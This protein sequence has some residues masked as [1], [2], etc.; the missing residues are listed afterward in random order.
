VFDEQINVLTVTANESYED[1]AGRCKPRLKDECGVTFDKGRIK[2]KRKRKRIKLKKQLELDKNFKELWEKIKHKTRYRVDYATDE[3]IRRAGRVVSELKITSARLVS[4]KARLEMDSG[5][6]EGVLLKETI[7]EVQDEVLMIPDVL[8]AIQGKTHLTRDTLLR[9]LQAAGRVG[10]IYTNPQLF[11]D[12][13]TA[14]ILRVLRDMMVDGIKYEKIAGQFWDQRLFDN[15]ELESYIDNL[16]AVKKQDKTLYNYIE[17]DSEIER[18]FAKELED[19]EDIKFYFKLPFWFRIQTP[20]GEYNPDWAIVFEGDKRVYFVAETKGTTVLE[21]LAVPEQ[22]KIRCGK[23]HFETMPD[24]MF[25]APITSVGE[26]I[27]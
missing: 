19:R 25:K 24:V 27:R 5:G 2:D 1:F 7:H 13:A 16:V 6:V 20:I 10:D 11:V 12:A 8:G 22:Y 18:R 14:S 4:R 26:L 21:D 23:K 9:I 15:E 17:V 3:L